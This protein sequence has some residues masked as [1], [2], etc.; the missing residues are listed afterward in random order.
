MRK[1]L[2]I[3]AILAALPVVVHSQ[4]L[5]ET[6]VALL[7]ANDHYNSNGQRLTE[8]WQ[9]IR[10]DRANFHRYGT[11][12]PQDEWDSF[13]GNFNNRAAAEQMLLNAFISPQAR[14]AIVNREVMIR[15]EVWGYGNTANALR[16][17]VY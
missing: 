12:D 6:Y 16:V 1:F 14:S 7:S 17:D 4:Q 2:L 8:P 10:Q 15:V 9:I 5:L 11:G 3:F 13:F